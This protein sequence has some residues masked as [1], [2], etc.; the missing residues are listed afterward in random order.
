LT[1]LIA[2]IHVQ[3]VQQKPIEAY[4]NTFAN[5]ALPLFAMAEP[6]PAK[7]FEYNSL[8]WSIWDRW[9]LEGDLTVQ[10]SE[11][12]VPREGVVCLWLNNCQWRLLAFV[13]E[14]KSASLG[15]AHGTCGDLGNTG[16]VTDVTPLTTV[17]VWLLMPLLR[18]AGGAGLVH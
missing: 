14:K 6:I 10:V 12:V 1:V 5:L 2:C 4:R 18:P 8:K 13:V 9:I 3:V 17:G 7:S 16:L 15:V 11:G